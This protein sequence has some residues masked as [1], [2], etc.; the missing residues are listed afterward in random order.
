MEEHQTPPFLH[1]F[2][3]THGFCGFYQASAKDNKYIHEVFQELL[4]K[5]RLI[6]IKR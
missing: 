1:N 4:G 6:Q 2:A 3:K 5:E